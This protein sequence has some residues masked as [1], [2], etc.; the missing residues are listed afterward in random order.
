MVRRDAPPE[1]APPAAQAG[2]GTY[3]LDDDEPLVAV[4]ESGTMDLSSLG[5]DPREVLGISVTDAPSAPGIPKAQAPR[6]MADWTL[7]E[8]HRVP[9]RKPAPSAAP[10]AEGLPQRY[11]DLGVIGHGGM[12]EVHR[13]RDRE[14]GRTLAMKFIHPELARS[15]SVMAR[16]LEEAQV[17]AQLQ[18]PGVVPVYDLGTLPDSR[19]FFTMKE[20]VGRTL[21][22]VIRDLHAAAEAGRD[23]AAGGWTFR[24]VIDAFLKVCE[25]VSYAHARGVIHRDLKPTNIMVGDFGEVMVADWGLAKV[26]GA[27]EPGPVTLEPVSTV[28]SQDEALATRAGGIAG[29]PAYMPPEQARADF[30]AVGPRS[31]VYALGAI[32]YEILSGAPPYD[33]PTAESVLAQVLDGPPP[34]PRARAL[35]IPDELAALCMH[36]MAHEPTARFPD[37]GHLAS[38][39][40]AWL[41]GA[42]KREQAQRLVDQA[43]ALLPE[44]DHLRSVAASLHQE[45]SRLLARV[46]PHDPVE[47]KRRGWAMQDEA[48]RLEWQAALKE[49]ELSQ[50]L[51]AALTHAPDL[52]QAHDMLAEQYRARHAAAEAQRDRLAAAHYLALLR[53]H[54]SGKHASYLRGDGMLTLW[55]DPPGAEVEL[56]VFERVERRLEAV[57]FRM[58]GR[59]PLHEVPLPMGSYLLRIRAP[60]RLEVVY[61]VQIGREEHWDGVPPGGSDPTPIILPRRDLL[62]P[63]DCYVPAGWAWVGGDP[64]AP[65]TLPKRR[66]WV[67]GFVLKRFP[68][69]N[70]AYVGFLNHLV[71]NGREED[72]QRHVPRERSGNVRDQGAPIYGRNA[73]G[74]FVLRQD[75]DGFFWGPTWPVASID[76]QSARAFC[77]WLASTT[78]TPWRLPGELEWEKAARGVDGRFYPWGDLLDPT[79]CNMAD[80]NPGSPAPAPVDA[81][82]S[83]ESP[84]GVQGMAGNVR[85]WCLDRW[86]ATGPD[87]LS[88]PDPGEDPSVL[89]V[90]RGGCWDGGGFACRAAGRLRVAAGRRGPDIGLRMARTVSGTG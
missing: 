49:V 29:T 48:D 69:T 90:V 87:E 19:A 81:F 80:T 43:S 35:R 45:A 71:A 7:F 46:R 30:D 28:R 15:R 12:G 24:R 11:E 64:E 23:E 58:L 51:G 74:R 10:S 18:H 4:V 34:P 89:R 38:E 20:I 14:L 78:G 68:V 75:A 25:T 36:A 77:A 79:W 72:A 40:S 88:G 47:R 42:R 44:M 62:G 16:F 6:A 59:T 65:G 22:D 2:A 33:G 55:T 31:D 39:L 17:T 67:D 54:D 53:R 66:V 86:S 32:L 3:A 1:D 84:Y 83:D 52:P 13:V 60:G 70:Q 9:L 63:D 27:P 41:D 85:D 76:Q 50:L 73:A 21:G 5:P 37:A 56:C 57:P 8:A 26:Q 82:P 61:P